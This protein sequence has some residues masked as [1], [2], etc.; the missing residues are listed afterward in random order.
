MKRGT[1]VLII[2][3]LLT[4]IMPTAAFGVSSCS[5]D[6]VDYIAELRSDGSA[7]ITEEWTVTFS[8][9]SDG[10][11]REII[12]PEDNFEVF[13]D[14]RDISVAVDGSGCSEVSS[15][16]AVSGTYALEKAENSY[17]INWFIPSENETRTFTLRYVLTGAVK[18]YN[19]RAYFFCTAANESDNLLC[20]NVTLTVK[21]PENCFAEDFVIVESDSLA[22]RKADGE[23][24][25]AAVNAA[26]L[27]RTGVS[28]P[29]QLFDTS[30]LVVILDDNTAEITV[31]VILLV[32]L[33]VCVGFGIYFAVNYKKL[34]RKHWEKKC[35]KKV[36]EEYSYRSQ[37]RL[38]EKFSPARIISIVSEKTASEADMFVVTFLDL[39][40]R[41]YI[42][43]ENSTLHSSEKSYTDSVKRPLNRNEKMLIQLFSS[44]S[45]KEIIS[46][47][48]SFYFFVKKFNAD[49]RF[50]NPFFA[51]S[52]NGRKTVR[53]CFEMKLSAGRHE[54]VSPAEIANGMWLGGK[55]TS[56][57]LII[58]L[59]N[60]YA[61]SLLPDYERETDG[62]Y[63]YDMFLLRDV[64]L[65]GKEIAE[66][67]ELDRLLKKKNR[68]KTAVTEDD[69]NTQ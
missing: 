27:I 45:W 23:V 53:L 29:V 39:L 36:Q 22:G 69:I 43:A 26:G 8:G 61:R 3:L 2:A 40:N 17:I 13:S 18:L 24:V 48:K 57:D 12:V 6:K 47:P 63:K 19:E 4:F 35:R 42:K 28:M 30:S 21:A 1:V 31:L 56:F 41:G 60:E 34:F 25:F 33:L 5:V 46:N 62:K 14:M 32:L 54:Y 38:L 16:S 50:V 64:F 15:T 67:E 20:R 49:V 11:T 55:Y 51:F 9:E 66:K 10:F 59:L 37:Q 52:S 58:S 44:N 7:L 65:E 68:K